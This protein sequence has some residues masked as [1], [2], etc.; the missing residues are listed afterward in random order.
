MGSPR[1]WITSSCELSNVGPG[2]RT[3]DV[4]ENSKC[5]LTTERSLHPLFMRIPWMCTMKCDHICPHLSLPNL[6]IPCQLQ[7]SVSF[8]HPFLLSLTLS[9]SVFVSS[10]L[11]DCSWLW[12]YLLEQQK[13]ASFFSPRSCQQPIASPLAGT[14]PPLLGQNSV[15][16]CPEQVLGGNHSC[17][18]S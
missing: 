1:A 7:I 14:A 3:L 18:C 4:C 13:R 12:D 16:F 6:S 11:S 15:C 2:N 10:S 17:W 9:L 8:P 5:S